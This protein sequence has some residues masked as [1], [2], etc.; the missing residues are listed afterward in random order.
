LVLLAVAA[1]VLFTVGRGAAQIASH[2]SCTSHPLAIN[3]AVSTDISQPI[4]EI[5]GAFNREHHQIDGRCVA[6]HVNSGSPALAAAQ[7]DGQHPNATGKPITAWIPD[8]SL[9]VDEVRGYPA[10]ARTVVPAGFSVARSPLMI[11]MPTVAAART[12]AFGKDGWKLLLPASAGGPRKPVNLSVDLPDPSLNAAGLAALIEESRLFGSGQQ[13]RLEFTQ[14]AHNATVTS[15][16]DGPSSLGSLVSLAAPPLNDDP[17]TVT[18]EQAVIAYDQANPR[19][20]AAVYPTGSVAA[21]GDPEFDY[22]YVLLASNTST[23]LDAAT[24]FGQMLRSSYATSVI[25]LIGFR[26]GG[27]SPGIPDRFAKSFG[28]ARQLLQIAQPASSLEA[29]TVLQSWNRVSLWSRDLVLI[30]ISGNMNGQSVYGAPT[31]EQELAKAATIGLG[32]FASTADLGL[33]VYAAHLT[34]ALPYK[35]MMPVG[36]LPAYVASNLTRRA[37]LERINGSLV[38]TP[39]DYVAL[40]GTIL[41]AYKYMQS[42][43]QPKF[44]NAVVVLGSGIENAPGDISGPALVR[45]L[46]R[47][48]NST[49]KVSIVMVTF[50]EPPNFHELQKIAESTGGQA[51]AITSPTQIASVFYKAIAHRL[52]TA[53][54]ATP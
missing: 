25:R 35:N 18:T 32:L 40:Y 22:P 1:C 12:P 45:E 14:F 41:D 2:V 27:P 21:L 42:I 19:A 50:G 17:V 33:W 47:L 34:G 9:W 38:T 30:D 23:Q 31:Y 39:N 8:S 37:A 24:A 28:L 7:I 6:V 54:C 46:T 48:D 3:V 52:C 13:A 43:Y 29:P 26:A 53:G 11:V 36:P 44:F 5:A 51:Y 4:N 49:R 20:L 16:F 15:Y 10:G